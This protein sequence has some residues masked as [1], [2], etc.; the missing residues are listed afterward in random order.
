MN[1]VK[2][3]EEY[4]FLK[5]KST[6]DTSWANPRPNVKDPDEPFF[7]VNKGAYKRKK[8]QEEICAALNM[9]YSEFEKFCEDVGVFYYSIRGAKLWNDKG[10]G[11]YD[12]NSEYYWTY[13]T[14]NEDQDERIFFIPD[15]NIVTV[16]IGGKKKIFKNRIYDGK[17]DLNTIANYLI[18]LEKNKRSEY[19]ELRKKGKSDR[20]KYLTTEDEPPLDDE[21]S[22]DK[23]AFD[24]YRYKS[25]HR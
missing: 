6:N 3:N 19:V 21:H 22:M 20:Y 11:T 13:L 18:N 2:T 9:S 23:S 12:S 24:S 4:K 16:T 10:I 17:P 7:N 25:K 5:V 1:H 14:G 15:K 8:D